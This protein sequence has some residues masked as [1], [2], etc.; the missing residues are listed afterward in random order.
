M[1]VS[2][3]AIPPDPPTAGPILRLVRDQRV[4]FVIVGGINTVVGFGWFV[5]YHELL[6]SRIGYMGALIC[7]HICAVLCAFVLHRRFV[8]KVTGHLLLDLARFEVVNLGALGFNLVMLPLLV[9]VVGM[10]AVPAQA[11]I[12]VVTVIGSYVGHRLFSFRRSNS[13]SGRAS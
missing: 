9:E 11:V 4:A 6:G 1:V 12:T 13:N 5:F 3:P 2:E 10:S 7:A 8:F